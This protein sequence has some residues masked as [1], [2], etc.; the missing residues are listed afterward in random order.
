MNKFL[1]PIIILQAR[2]GSSRLPNKMMLPFYKEQSILDILLG[3]L[4]GTFK[5]EQLLVATTVNSNDNGIKELCDKVNVRC[6]RGS[7]EDVLDRFISAASNFH[8]E[9]IIRICA[10]NVFLDLEGL[11]KLYE[12][13]D[14]LDVDYVAYQTSDL[15]PSIKTHY[16]FWAEGVSLRALRRV[17]SVTDEKLYHEHVT[18]YIYTVPGDFKFLYLRIDP[19]IES[20]KNLRLTVDTLADFMVQQE[21]YS[22]LVMNHISITPINIIDYLSTHPDLYEIMAKNIIENSK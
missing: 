4:L 10:D 20:H 18:N 16:G 14:L 19:E 21:I 13:L 3:R 8:A 1:Q 9:K 7:E 11:K 22:Y 15:K 5:K 17:A 6:W 12:V 2:T